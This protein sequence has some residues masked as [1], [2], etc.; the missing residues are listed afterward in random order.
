MINIKWSEIYIQNICSNYCFNSTN[1]SDSV[2]ITRE[3]YCFGNV[4]FE[5][6]FHF[7]VFFLFC[8]QKDWMITFYTQNE[9]W[10]RH[11]FKGYTKSNMESTYTQLPK[12]SIYFYQNSLNSYAKQGREKY[13]IIVYCLVYLLRTLLSAFESLLFIN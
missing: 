8:Y 12:I 1:L 10:L 5:F 4:S 3:I 2:A 7:I 11:S 6:D 13:Q 9:S